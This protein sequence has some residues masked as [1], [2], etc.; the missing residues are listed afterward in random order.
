[1]IHVELTHEMPWPNSLD[2][3][4]LAVRAARDHCDDRGGIDEQC[5]SSLSES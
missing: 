4:G 5:H 2:W 1:M 3:D